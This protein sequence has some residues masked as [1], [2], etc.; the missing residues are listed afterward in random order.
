MSDEDFDG[1]DK[2]LDGVISPD[3]SRTATALE[4]GEQLSNIEEY[5]I[6]FDDGNSV[7][8]GLKSTM[9]D[10]EMSTLTQYPISFAAQNE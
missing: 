3:V 2:N 4:L 9:Y 1:W 10:S 8:A 5:N 6:Y 7:M